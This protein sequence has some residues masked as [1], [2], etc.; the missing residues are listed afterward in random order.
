M[1][2][3]DRTFDRTIT[4]DDLRIIGM[5]RLFS[6]ITQAEMVSLLPCLNARK[7]KFDKGDWILRAGNE[8]EES[9]ILLSGSA[10]IERSDYWGT[11]HIV[12]ALQPGD[13]FG[14]SYAAVRNSVLSVSVQAD[15]ETSILRLDL[16]KMLQMCASACPFHTRL[17]ENLVGLLA[18]RNL[19]LNEKLTYITQHSLRDKIL[20][21]LSSESIRQHASYFDIPFDR[22]QL[23]DYLNADRSAL[24]NELSKLKA[25]G[26]ID[27]QKNHF[28]LKI[29]NEERN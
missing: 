7:Q 13:L 22:Q 9:G 19:H 16:T 29:P 11:R 23:A 24:S 10:H 4:E 25:E 14:E 18:Q 8:I 28:Y 27:Y 21:Y 12:S 3:T 2:K 17:I 26:I 6:G 1:K 20:S 15:E 5:S